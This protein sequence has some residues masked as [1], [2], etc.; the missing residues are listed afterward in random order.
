MSVYLRAA[1]AALIVAAAP[2]GAAW[3]IV[4]SEPGK[5]VEV[6]RASIVADPGG[7]AMAKGRVV[8]DKPIV[9]PKTSAS[10][11]II[12]AVNRYDCIERTSATL[13]RSYYKEEGEL[14]REE[15]VRNPFDMPVRSGT[16]DDKLLREACRPQSPAQAVVAANRTAGKVSEAAGDLRKA[17]AALIEQEVGKEAKRAPRRNT[18]ASSSLR[19]LASAAKNSALPPNTA[20]AYAGNGGPDNWSKL[21][22][23]YATCA[24]G[25]RQSPIDLADGI[26]V[27]LEPIQFNY[28]PA[29][30]LVVD[31]GRN[32]QVAVYG[33][34]LTLLGKSYELMRIQFHRPSEISVGGKVFDMDAQLMHKA[35]DGKLLIVAVPLERGS[36]NPLVQMALN[37]VPLEPGGDVMPPAQNIDLNRLLPESRRYFTF[38][39]SLTTPPCTEDVV[40]VVIKQPQSV[41]PEQLAIFQ[42]LYPPNARPLQ[43]AFGRIVKESR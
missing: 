18:A 1:L 4:A 28:S 13:K 26:A 25:R 43:A 23:E 19:V 12:E 21:K 10:Y 32:L 14:L 5:R 20:W 41:S 8:L 7:E 15:E 33:G 22:A 37:N 35:A 39:G 17:N 29:P 2:A 24:S 3:Q 31:S 40:W 42:R 27:D 34:G 11:R 30:F 9:D 38:M 36:E 6:D 16:P